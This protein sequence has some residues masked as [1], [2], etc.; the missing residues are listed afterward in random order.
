L[1]ILTKDRLDY[2]VRTLDSLWANTPTGFD[3]YLV[4]NGSKDGSTEYFRKHA[5]RFKRMILNP[6]NRGISIGHNQALDAIGAGYDYIVQMDNDCEIITYGWLEEMIRVIRGLDDKAVLSPFVE[7]LRENK[8]GAPRHATRDVAGHIV[9]FSQHVG[10]I[11]VVAPGSVFSE[12]RY[13][14]D[15][16]LHGNQDV[17]FSSHVLAHGLELGYV[18]DVRVRHMD[19]TDGQHERYPDYFR[20]SEQESRTLYGHSRVVSELLLKLRGLRRRA[21]RLLQRDGRP[22]A[23]H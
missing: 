3:L 23:G 12:F 8:G 17:L 20:Q 19:G 15:E 18:E 21:R 6:D 10:G 1:F 2:T 4:D 11:S 13:P 16:P 22:G 5:D 7:G 9:G 14:V